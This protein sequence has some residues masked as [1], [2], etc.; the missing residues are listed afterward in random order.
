MEFSTL[1]INIRSFAREIL[2]VLSVH[3]TTIT[4][5]LYGGVIKLNR[6]K[7]MRFYL[8]GPMDHDR[9]AGRDWRVEMGN[10]LNSRKALYLDPYN[11]PLMMGEIGK[12]DDETYDKVTVALSNK[13]DS[14]IRRLMKPVVSIDLRMVDHADA[15]IVNLDKDKHPCGTF[16]ELFMSCLESKPTIVMCPQGKYNIHRWL[17]GRI[18]YQFFFD[19][20]DGVKNYLDYIDTSPQVETLDRWKFFDMADQIRKVMNME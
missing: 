14:E 7:L 19:S 15:I 4:T 16:D 8:V 1:G 17:W 10:W 9:Q 20:W 2:L 11:K 18:P 5:S 6:L 12:E 3:L 13:D